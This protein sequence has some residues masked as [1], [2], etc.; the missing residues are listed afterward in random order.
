MSWI[1]GIEET[2]YNPGPLWSFS[3][4]LLAVRDWWVKRK[5]E[6]R[7]ERLATYDWIYECG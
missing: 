7:A 4:N 2:P 6:K 1:G 5:R 3:V